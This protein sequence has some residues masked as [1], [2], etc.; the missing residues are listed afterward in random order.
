MALIW[1]VLLGIYIYL[2]VG[3][4][5]YMFSM[6]ICLKYPGSW[7]APFECYDGADAI[8]MIIFWPLTVLAY[9]VGVMTNIMDQFNNFLRER[10]RKQ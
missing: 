2:I 4:A 8:I 1:K 9:I 7:F 5:V 10:M 3:F 6:L